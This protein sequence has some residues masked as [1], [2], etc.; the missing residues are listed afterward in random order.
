M[1]GRALVTGKKDESRKKK[2]SPLFREYFHP[3]ASFSVP[4]FF[5][6]DKLSLS[7]FAV[8]YQVFFYLKDARFQREKISILACGN[9]D[10][11]THS[12]MILLNNFPYS[13]KIHV[14]RCYFRAE[15][16]DSVFIIN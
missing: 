14:A 8:Q 1:Q 12:P 11:N 2:I 16:C 15:F 13:G 4:N 5:V 10:R 3:P 9:I 6:H 7:S